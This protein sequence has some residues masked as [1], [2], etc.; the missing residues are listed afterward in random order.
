[1]ESS[2]NRMRSG[3]RDPYKDLTIRVSLLFR[4]QMSNLVG[5]KNGILR[6][7]GR[8]GVL[9]TVG[10]KYRTEELSINLN[11]ISVT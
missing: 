3:R 9:K 1:M 5:E 11:Q 4:S 8:I 2:A 10:S 7:G 6:E